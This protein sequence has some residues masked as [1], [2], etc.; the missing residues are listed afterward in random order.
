VATLF[1]TAT[2][3]RETTGAKAV[4]ERFA[5]RHEITERE[6]RIVTEALRDLD[7]DRAKLEVLARLPRQTSD[8][9]DGPPKKDNGHP[10]TASR[11][12]TKRPAAKVARR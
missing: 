11:P 3:I 1:P 4:V 9:D 8:S 7:K 12:A 6:R 10:P 5:G 2:T